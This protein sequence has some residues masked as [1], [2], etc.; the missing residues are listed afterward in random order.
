MLLSLLLGNVYDGGDDDDDYYYHP[1]FN[2]DQ[3]VQFSV[4]YCKPGPL[5]SRGKIIQRTNQ[6]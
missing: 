1:Y 3:K 2:L 6:S 4:H 5:S